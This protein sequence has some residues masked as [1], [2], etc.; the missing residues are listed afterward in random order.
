[1]DLPRS[2]AA[3][4]LPLTP[5]RSPYRIPCPDKLL[6]PAS[7]PRAFVQF[8]P[9]AWPSM[10]RP[11]YRKR[12]RV[13]D[14]SLDQSP[15]KKARSNDRAPGSSN[16][17]PEFYDDL[18]RRSQLFLTSRALRELDRRND[19]LHLSNP[20]VP[21]TPFASVEEFARQNRRGGPDLC[22][23]RGVS[24]PAFTHPFA[25]L[26][27][28]LSTPSRRASHAQWPPHRRRAASAY[29]QAKRP[30]SPPKANA[31]LPTMQILNSISSTTIS[32]LRSIA[33]PMATE[34]PS[35]PIGKNSG[36]L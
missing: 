4:L 23:L 10:A 9:P 16:F 1:M 26:T 7:T 34:P 6:H 25:V 30:P 5:G 2:Q 20:T 13:D 14:P 12:Q 24:M 22:D 11:Q 33:F 18:S 3:A 19:Q 28:L 35:Q 21:G 27:D 31:P 15:P 36:A 29:S 32:T 8:N 17:P